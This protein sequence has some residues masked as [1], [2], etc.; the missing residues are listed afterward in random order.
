MVSSPQLILGSLHSISDRSIF[1][2]PLE[3]DH[4]DLKTVSTAPPSH[5]SVLQR[6]GLVAKVCVGVTFYEARV[7]GTP[8]TSHTST[9]RDTGE[10]GPTASVEHH[11][12]S[13]A[14][15]KELCCLAL[16]HA[17]LLCAKGDELVIP[18]EFAATPWPVHT[19]KQYT[20]LMEQLTARRA[21]TAVNTSSFCVPV[22]SIEE[23]VYKHKGVRVCLGVAW[24]PRYSHNLRQW[25]VT[26]AAS[27]HRVPEASLLTLLHH[28]TTGALA[29]RTAANVVGQTDEALSLSVTLEKVLVHRGSKAEK[30]TA[31]E[32]DSGNAGGGL[33]FVLT[34][35]AC[36][37]RQAEPRVDQNSGTNEAACSGKGRFTNHL[38]VLEEEQ[39]L[40]RTPEDCSPRLYPTHGSA[41]AKRDAWTLGVVLYLLASGLAGTGR[42]AATSLRSRSPRRA[43]MRKL[44]PLNAAVLTPDSLWRRLRRELECRGYSGTIVTVITQLLSL[45][46]LTR[47]SLSTVDRMLQDLQRPT[48]VHRFPFALGSYDLLRMQNPADID[49]NPGAR[50][51]T[52]AGACILCKKQR[53]S[54]AL[55]TKGG[56]HVPG[57]SSPSWSDEELLPQLP[58]MDLHY[59]TFLYPLCGSS[60]E[61]QRRKQVALA[62]QGPPSSMN[63]S[64]GVAPVTAPLLDSTRL[65]QVFGGFAVYKRM[66]ELNA[67]GQVFYRVVVKDVL[68]P[69]PSQGLRRSE[70]PLVKLTIDF[71]GGLPWPSCCTEALQKSGRVSRNAPFS[72][73][74]AHQGVE[75]FGWVLPGER[76]SLPN[77]GHWTAPH[78]GAFVFLFNSDLRPTDRDRYFGLTSMRAATLPAKVPRTVLPDSLFRLHAGDEAR[79]SGIF[80]SRTENGNRADPGLRRSSVLRCSVVHRRSCHSVT[81][82]A[83]PSATHEIVEAEE[84]ASTALEH[85][86]L[87]LSASQLRNSPGEPPVNGRRRRSSMKDRA[88][89]RRSDMFPA[90]VVGFLESAAEERKSPGSALAASVL[91][92]ASDTASS[93]TSGTPE[94]NEP[95]LLLGAPRRDTPVITDRKNPKS[96]EWA[97]A[98]DKAQWTDCNITRLPVCTNTSVDS[99][100]ALA[101]PEGSISP[102][103]PNWLASWRQKA[104]KPL[105]MTMSLQGSRGA[106]AEGLVTSLPLSVDAENV[107]SNA[108]VTAQLVS[109][110]RNSGRESSS[111]VFELRPIAQR[112]VRK[113][114]IHA[115]LP[116]ATPKLPPIVG[117]LPAGLGEMRI[118]GLWLPSEAVDAAFR[119]LT[120][121]VFSTGEH[122]Y[123]H[124][125][126]KISARVAHAIR[127]LPGAAYL[128]FLSNQLP[129]FRRNHPRME[130]ATC[131]LMLPHHGFTCYASD[132]TLLGVLAL[133]CSRNGCPDV[134][135]DEFELM[136]R[137]S[138][139]F[140]G[141]SV[142]SRTV[143]ASYLSKDVGAHMDKA[144]AASGACEVRNRDGEEDGQASPLRHVSSLPHRGWGTRKLLANARGNQARTFSGAFRHVND[145]TSNENDDA[146]PS[147]T[148]E[149]VLPACWVGFDGL[150]AALLFADAAQSV[151][152][153]Y[154]IGG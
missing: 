135:S 51:Y 37:W 45:D 82:V 3:N 130:A 96:P 148:R 142:A 146:S 54:T 145:C 103:A 27:G 73:T 38:I 133:R 99:A 144:R 127:A 111:R 29:M 68:V 7:S 152:V 123:M 20:E 117:T 126:V 93:H 150:S 70:L 41:A 46:P 58:C 11:S 62:L 64:I 95:G 39:L 81:D 119:A 65:F 6:N 17:G 113:E 61:R 59:M 131:S 147:Q 140:H 57:L 15:R 72:F 16:V 30:K 79:V 151:W 80:G 76:F 35:G 114:S 28:V 60:D 143:Y 89:S 21:C 98:R 116:A 138:T 132:G 18:E 36:E 52:M 32:V 26:F 120:F 23:C 12:L 69:Y 118:G 84:N 88:P 74:G 43:C 75:W 90:I 49:L 139:A 153:P 136:T 77:G 94:L 25:A 10:S 154:R 4:L 92:S 50:R 91:R 71:S 137:V 31:K 63:A 128:A 24:M 109:S 40:Y 86:P 102:T 9:A 105:G 104:C 66:P 67:K 87:S 5:R 83:L 101:P 122:G 14:K 107:I 134:M 115:T 110:T 124:P 34:T 44:A 42:A 1:F 33:A 125:P 78:D 108:A 55:C 85:R 121:C 2:T 47:P 112:R 149:D 19:E 56:D 22:L 141:S 53:D 13:A 129:L 100:R 106:A 48:P 8:P 97:E